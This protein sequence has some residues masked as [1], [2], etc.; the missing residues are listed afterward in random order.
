MTSPNIPQTRHSTLF[1][2]VSHFVGFDIGKETNLHNL[3]FMQNNYMGEDWFCSFSREVPALSSKEYLKVMAPVQL[4]SDA[5]NNANLLSPTCRWL[6]CLVQ[7]WWEL[8][9]EER[10]LDTIS[11]KIFCCFRLQDLGF[12]ELP[13]KENLH[14]SSTQIFFVSLN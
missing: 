2:G 7:A 9:S 5:S 4:C 8:Q 10:S 14:F 12:P 1:S 6:H 13:R 3:I 11:E